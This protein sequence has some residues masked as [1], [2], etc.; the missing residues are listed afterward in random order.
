MGS[1]SPLVKLRPVSQLMSAG[2]WKVAGK[3]YSKPRRAGPYTRSLRIE[4]GRLVDVPSADEATQVD[5][6]LLQRQHSLADHSTWYQ[7]MLSDASNQLSGSNL[8]TESRLCLL[9]L[10]RHDVEVEESDQR[11]GGTNSELMQ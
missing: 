5:Q 6:Y 11:R 7:H 8:Q 10:P 9:T 1:L 4:D 2:V 3:S